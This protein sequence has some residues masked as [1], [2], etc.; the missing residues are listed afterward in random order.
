MG[1]E[2]LPDPGEILWLVFARRLAHA[3]HW[4]RLTVEP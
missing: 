1:Q 3:P 4:G 2:P